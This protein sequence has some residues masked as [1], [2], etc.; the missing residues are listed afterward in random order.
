MVRPCSFAYQLA[1]HG[2]IPKIVR[3]LS[4]MDYGYEN[5]GDHYPI[6]ERSVHTSRIQIL[7]KRRDGVPFACINRRKYQ[8]MTDLRLGFK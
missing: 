6:T 3:V 7:R 1:P 8:T 2:S 4:R 5:C